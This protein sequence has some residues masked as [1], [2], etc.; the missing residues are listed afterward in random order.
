MF[1]LKSY[2]RKELAMLYFPGSKPKAAYFNLRRW[3]LEQRDGDALLKS[4][5]QKR[6]LNKD[7]VKSIV[8]L[9]GEP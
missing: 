4:V 7:A 1:E 8:D 3:L 5:H 9:L 6:I 2:S